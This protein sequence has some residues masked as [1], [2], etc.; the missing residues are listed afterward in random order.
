MFA[1][2]RIDLETRNRK[3]SSIDSEHYQLIQ[4][5]RYSIE[6]KHIEGKQPPHE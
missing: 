5:E 1:E 4:K 3:P 6:L 2:A